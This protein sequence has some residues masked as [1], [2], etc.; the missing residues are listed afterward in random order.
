VVELE[1][2]YI[3]D[4]DGP[5]DSSFLTSARLRW[6][7]HTY[8]DAQAVHEEFKTN[9]PDRAGYISPNSQMIIFDDVTREIIFK[10]GAI[11]LGSENSVEN[12]VLGQVFQAMMSTVLNLIA[13]HIH[14]SSLGPTGPPHNAALFQAQKTSP[15]DDGLILSDYAFT[16]KGVPNG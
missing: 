11:K 14:T 3:E 13:V 8:S 5:E 7:G 12:L 1:V 16:E 2:V 10:F 4:D 9:Y 6:R 15:I